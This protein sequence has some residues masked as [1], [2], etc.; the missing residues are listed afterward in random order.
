MSTVSGAADDPRAHDV[1]SKVEQQGRLRDQ[2][3]R[4]RDTAAARRDHH[5]AR[6]DEAADEQRR[7]WWALAQP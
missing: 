3:S 6:R 7:D 5:G 4:Q 1:D 2:A